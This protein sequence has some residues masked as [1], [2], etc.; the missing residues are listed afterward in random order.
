MC[1]VWLHLQKLNLFITW[2]LH[3]IYLKVTLFCHISYIGI[4]IVFLD[5]LW[6]VWKCFLS[7]MWLGECDYDDACRKQCTSKELLIFLEVNTSTFFPTKYWHF[8][9]TIIGTFFHILFKTVLKIAETTREQVF[10]LWFLYMFW[11]M[12]KF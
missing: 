4:V 11:A 9:K 10:F 12:Q 7:K 1:F 6:R 3:C 5:H 2:F 8:L